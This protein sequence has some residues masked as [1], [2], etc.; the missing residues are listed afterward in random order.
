M[1]NSPY[2]L[3]SVMNPNGGANIRARRK[4]YYP[5]V[6]F[7]W[8]PSIQRAVSDILADYGP[9]VFGNRPVRT[10]TPGGVGA[11]GEKPPATRFGFLKS[12]RQLILAKLIAP[13]YLCLA[14]LKFQVS[15]FNPN[16]TTPV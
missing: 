6:S 10:R 2:V 5:Q 13:L 4:V 15:H 3:R 16:F 11:G 7:A 8:P 12:L 1:R 14:L 9:L